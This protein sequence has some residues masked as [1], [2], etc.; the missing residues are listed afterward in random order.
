MV[1]NKI[2]RQLQDGLGLFSLGLGTAQLAAPGPMTRLIG[3]RDT[4]RNRMLH[5]WGGGAR[6]F[7]VGTGIM[8]HTMPAV[9]MWSRVAGDMVD[10]SV[11]GAIMANPRR[12]NSRRNAAI[13]TAAVAGVTAAD[14]VTG[15]RLIR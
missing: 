4:K 15:V 8:S 6:E 1:T 7:G 12:P 5:R 10:L 3:A 2:T 9:W 13:S 11:L 14:I